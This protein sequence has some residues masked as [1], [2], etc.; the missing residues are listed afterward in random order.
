MK[1]YKKKHIFLFP[2][3]FIFM[4]F[5]ILSATMIIIGVSVFFMIHSGIISREFLPS[6][7]IY[8]TILLGV[9]SIIIG[10]IVS[11]FIC[12]IPL[13]PINI[14]IDA[15]N[16]LADGEYDTRIYIS[17][18]KYS[19][20]IS[21]SFNKLADELQN[22]EMLR[23]DFVNDFSHE[24]K[25]PIVSIKGF[26]K[27]IKKGNISEQ[28]KAEYLDIIIDESSRLADMATNILNLTKL[29]NQ[30][31]LTDITEYN[32]S[33]QLR[34]CILLLEKKW[35]RKNLNISVNFN[36]YNIN[37]NEELLKQVWINLIDNAVKFADENGDVEISIKKK[38]DML[39]I[40]VYNSGSSVKDEDKKRIFNK[41][42]QGDTSHSK[43]GTGTGLAVVK[44]ITELHKGSVS[45]S[46]KSGGV[47]FTVC[48]PVD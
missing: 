35:S 8:F 16:H 17:D 30:N 23:S 12:H 47:V 41:F 3:I 38:D 27:L 32:L 29:E 42:Y 20:K 37:A 33:E 46:E 43:E 5:L 1:K 18:N 13:K 40:S 10:T 22:T 45:V 9:A 11:A 44:K 14:L 24:F 2:V 48:L 19:A 21:E 6:P 31:I 26:A 15:M 4:V 7:V 39:E 34:N 36:E 28:E 25:T